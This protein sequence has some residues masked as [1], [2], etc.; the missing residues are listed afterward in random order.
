MYWS[1]LFEEQLQL[2]NIFVILLC[3]WT[4]YKYWPALKLAKWKVMLV[5]THG[6]HSF[7]EKTKPLIHTVFNSEDF[8]Q[9]KPLFLPG[10]VSGDHQSFWPWWRGTG[11][12][13]LLLASTEL[14]G[15][16]SL[17]VCAVCAPGG[18]PQRSHLNSERQKSWEGQ[19]LGPAEPLGSRFAL[20]TAN[21]FYFWQVKQF[22]W[23]PGDSLQGI[24]TSLYGT[25]SSRHW[26][27]EMG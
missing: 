9:I 16:S 10:K 3:V 1:V 12:R 17:W 14:G 21:S 5:D 8:Q 25:Q 19:H 18:L 27:T 13:P 22:Y 4:S 6:T 20:T 15:Y 7:W 26:F 24:S 2:L 23:C 11:R